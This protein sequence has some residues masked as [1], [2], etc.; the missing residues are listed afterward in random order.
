M[1]KKGK[2]SHLP[3][4]TTLF[5]STPALTQEEELIYVVS[6]SVAGQEPKL[7]QKVDASLIF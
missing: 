2:Q 5:H 4:S 7:T 6:S 3:T 1:K